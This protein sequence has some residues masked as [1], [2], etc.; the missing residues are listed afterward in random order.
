[1]AVPP[2]GLFG[3]GLEFRNGNLLFG[4]VYIPLKYDCCSRF[5]ISY[6]VTTRNLPLNIGVQWL[7]PDRVFGLFE[8]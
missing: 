3:F 7:D 2:G 1:M 5:V 8:E 6:A 4:R